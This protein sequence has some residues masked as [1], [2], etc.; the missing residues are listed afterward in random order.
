MEDGSGEEEEEDRGK[1]VLSRKR[2]K[3]LKT[4]RTAEEGKGVYTV[5]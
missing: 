5:Q 4:Q 2:G 3:I 1:K